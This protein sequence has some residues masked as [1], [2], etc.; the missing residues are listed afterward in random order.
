MK[1]EKYTDIK[2][3]LRTPKYK[4]VRE[5]LSQKHGDR[6]V[7]VDKLVATNTAGQVID[8]DEKSMDRF[9]RVISLGIAQVMLATN[10]TNTAW[11][12][13]VFPWVDAN[14]KVIQVSLRQAVELQADGLNKLSAVWGV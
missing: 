13:V 14:N 2:G 3:A 7:A 5:T 8:A 11:D 10:P 9:D 12:A 6:T 4:E 1:L